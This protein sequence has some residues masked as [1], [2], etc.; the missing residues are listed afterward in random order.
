[1]Y[2]VMKECVFREK[3]TKMLL[4]GRQ[5]SGEYPKVEKDTI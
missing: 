5:L 3:K 4:S 1:M 2:D